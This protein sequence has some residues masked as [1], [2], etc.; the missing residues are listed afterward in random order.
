LKLA[1]GEDDQPLKP[2]RFKDEKEN[3]TKDLESPLETQIGILFYVN[4]ILE[5]QLSGLAKKGLGCEGILVILKTGE[6]NEIPIPVSLAKET[7]D[8]KTFVNL[9]RLELEKIILP[10]PV[11]KIQ[12]RIQTTSPLSSEQL[13]LHQR[14]EANPLDKIF[15]RVKRVLGNGNIL[16]P[17]I[18]SS[19]RPEGKLQLVRYTPSK[20]NNSK[21]NMVKKKEQKKTSPESTESQIGFCQNS[22]SGFRLY[23]PPKPATVR[24]ENGVIKF[25]IADSWYGEVAKQKGPWE[26][27][28]EWW[29]EAYHR[30]Y[31]EV[32]LSRGEQYLI[33]FDNFLQKWFLQGI[34]D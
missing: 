20:K 19:H 6:D 13:S 10:D 29:S 26:I 2:K 30:C 21:E 11:R 15:I 7:N 9:F 33:F 24:Q 22:I 27:S 16:S 4:S 34:F 5:S 1:R 23:H 25:V 28:G 8:P 14:K 18:I 31:F 17:Q 32:E 3:Q 12:V